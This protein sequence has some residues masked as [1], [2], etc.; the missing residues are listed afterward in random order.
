MI[1][2]IVCFCAH[3][4]KKS[5][6]ENPY[7]K[8]NQVVIGDALPTIKED[9]KRENDGNEKQKDNQ[10]KA[11][12][13]IAKIGET[14]T[15]KIEEETTQKI[16]EKTTQKIEEKKDGNIV[17]KPDDNKIEEKKDNITP[18]QPGNDVKEQPVMTCKPKNLE[19]LKN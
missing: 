4:F 1:E 13:V 2:I 17:A 6:E 16:E 7:D 14:N 5:E 8:S 3:K 18:Q 15:Q 9:P 19:E 12:N 11:E 10:Q